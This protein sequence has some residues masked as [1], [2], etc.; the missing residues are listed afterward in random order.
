MTE[1]PMYDQGEFKKTILESIQSLVDAN[2]VTGQPIVSGDIT[3]IPVFKASIGLIS[4]G[5]TT[6][7]ERLVEAVPGI[8]DKLT[9]ILAPKE[10]E[11]GT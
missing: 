10:G 2:V 6:A 11:A 9:A 4:A 5:E 7:M 1:K 3:I 8:V